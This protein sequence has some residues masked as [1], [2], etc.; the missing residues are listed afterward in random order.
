MNI[1]IFLSEFVRTVIIMSISGGAIALLLLALKPL[2]RHRLPKAWQYSFWIVAVLVF[3]IPVSRIAVIPGQFGD[4][5]PVYT[6][7]ARAVV[8]TT[9]EPARVSHM[10]LTPM[11]DRLPQ[12]PD[13]NFIPSNTSTTTIERPD[14]SFEFT[15]QLT[16]AT[17]EVHLPPT[18]AAI[19]STI[20]MLVYPFV[21]ALVLIYNLIGYAVFTIKLRRGRLSPM[22]EELAMLTALTNRKVYLYR[23]TY[24]A[25]PM[26][27]SLFRPTIILPNRE[28]TPLQ[29]ESILLHEVTHMR[30][31]DILIK[32]ITL[33]AC[34]LHWFNPLVWLARAEINRN[35]ELS[36]DEAVIRHMDTSGKQGYGNTLID[37]ATDTKIPLPVLSTTMCEEK[38]ALKERL[39]AIMKSKKHTKLA[40]FISILVILTAILAA[41]TLGASRNA[42]EDAVLTGTDNASDNNQENSQANNMLA[43][44]PADATQLDFAQ[45]HVQFRADNLSHHELVRVVDNRIDEF[46]LAG[47]FTHIMPSTT[48]EVWRLEFAVQ[49]EV[50]CWTVRWGTFEPGEGGWFSHDTGYMDALTHLVFTRDSS[51]LQYLGE[52]SM[53]ISWWGSSSPWHI[54]YLVRDFLEQQELISPVMFPG[55]HKLVYV[56]V[57]AS[58]THWRLLLSQPVIQG[59]GGIWAIERLQS[60]SYWGFSTQRPL[61]HHMAEIDQLSIMGYYEQMQRYYDEGVA[62]W[63]SDPVNVVLDNLNDDFTWWGTPSIVAVHDVSGVALP[64]EMP[65]HVDAPQRD[66]DT[67]EWEEPEWHLTEPIDTFDHELRDSMLARIGGLAFDQA[68]QFRLESGRYALITGWRPL[69]S[70]EEVRRYFPGTS[71]PEQ[72]GDF[73]LQSVTTLEH[74]GAAVR[75]SSVPIRSTAYNIDNYFYGRLFSVDLRPYWEEATLP[76]NEPFTRNLWITGF[77]AIYVNSQGQRIAATFHLNSSHIAPDMWLSAFPHTTADIDGEVYFVGRPGE[78]AVAVRT[79]E[80]IR[81]V[82]YRMEMAFLDSTSVD[83]IHRWG[84]A[85][86]HMFTGVRMVERAELEQLVRDF[87]SAAHHTEHGIWIMNSSPHHLDDWLRRW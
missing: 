18:P 31:L 83:E 35:C 20:F 67:W 87:D 58:E 82:H 50:D 17:G 42:V 63:M 8:S 86:N 10:P 57:E 77:T 80:S 22:P 27:I 37:I 41:C 47:E 52:I 81:D 21:A 1:P 36:C 39:T 74:T 43:S 84:W 12:I 46:V 25:T 71:I 24:A 9:E 11:P 64:F 69:T 32:W 48:L 56:Y 23:C 78:Y 76:L 40:I 61:P 6:A 66:W 75:L 60:L 5:A 68:Y 49:V 73:R 3:L 15:P 79:F 4:I 38:R 72:I 30:R 33:A 34:A 62:T 13:T 26:L 19:A 14:S 70:I 51:G 28:Y 55:N 85:F 44:L 2:V 53:S 65:P 54:E 7:V 45:A 29:L 16:F 59:E